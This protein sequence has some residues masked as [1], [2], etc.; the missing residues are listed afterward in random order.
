MK[1]ITKTMAVGFYADLCGTYNGSPTRYGQG[2][3]SVFHIAEKMHITQEQAEAYC[4]A[5]IRYGITERQ[6]GRIVI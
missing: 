3:A 2:V 5:L 4:S 6:G 1:Y